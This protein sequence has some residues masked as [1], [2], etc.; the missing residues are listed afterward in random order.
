MMRKPPVAVKMRVQ[1][2]PGQ[3]LIEGFTVDVKADSPQ[4]MHSMGNDRVLCSL[5]GTRMGKSAR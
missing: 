2:H 4:M 3:R 5:C 1:G